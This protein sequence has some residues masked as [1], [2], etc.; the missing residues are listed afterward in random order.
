[1]TVVFQEFTNARWRRPLAVLGAIAGTIAAFGNVATAQQPMY[2][3]SSGYSRP[4]VIVDLSVLDKLGPA[5]TLPGLLR[6]PRAAP[7][8]AIPGATL[9][10]PPATPPS[11]GASG[12]M[13]ARSIT[14]ISAS[15]AA[16]VGRP[17]ARW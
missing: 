11:A 3:Y 16:T 17:S 6:T 13:R 4:S 8:A 9:L 1:M 7:L 10:P 15:P 14:A 5:P 12:S 2:V